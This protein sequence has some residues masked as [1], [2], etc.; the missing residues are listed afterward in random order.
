[1]LKFGR[2]ISAQRCF[3]D[4]SKAE[5][6]SGESSALNS[7]SNLAKAT[8]RAVEVS[9]ANGAKPQSS[10]NPNWAG[11]GKEA[12]SI[13]R[14]RTGEYWDRMARRIADSSRR[15]RGFAEGRT[16][17]ND[18]SPPS[19]DHAPGGI[20]RECDDRADIEI[21]TAKISR[22]MADGTPKPKDELSSKSWWLGHHR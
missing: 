16:D 2:T 6:S 9:S 1:M 15:W 19:L 5:L 7:G 21:S 18:S 13:T 22:L 12:A 10:A 3:D 11:G 8:S 17:I 4:R 14:P 20:F